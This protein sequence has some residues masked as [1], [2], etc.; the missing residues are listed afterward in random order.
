MKNR[1]SI[2]LAVLFLGLPPTPASALTLEKMV[3]YYLGSGDNT[4]L[5]PNQK[6]IGRSFANR[7]KQLSSR[8][9]TDH[10]SGHISKTEAE[11]LRFELTRLQDQYQRYRESDGGFTY[12]ETTLL[13]QDFQELTNRLDKAV[14]RA[15]KTVSFDDINRIQAQ[16]RDRLEIAVLAGKLS[17][18]EADSLRFSLRWTDKLK[19]ELAQRTGFTRAN[20]EV[21]SSALSR[22]ERRLTRWSN[23]DIAGSSHD[24]L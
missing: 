3:K 2:L 9:A 1:Y 14:A 8:I 17:R 22:V 15:M 11:K 16:L 6:L 19:A 24:R 21:I 13:V 12:G 18:A 4:A 10:K 20:H 7:E 23:N 5:T